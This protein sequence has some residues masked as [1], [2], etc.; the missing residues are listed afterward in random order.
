MPV[1]I[2]T[3][4]KIPLSEI[5]DAQREKHS[6]PAKFVDARLE[7]ENLVLSFTLEQVETTQEEQALPP[8][9]NPQKKRRSKRRNRMRTRGW[10]VIARLTNSRGQKC[11][12]YKPFV[13]ALQNKED[14]TIDEQRKK[15]EAILRANRNRPSEDSIRYFLDNTLEYLNGP[16][17]EVVQ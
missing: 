14:L 12:I 9:T 3:I 2:Q 10:P 5:A 13:D 7:G 15:V 11:S 17:G 8:I 4:I 1:E 16:K 6:L